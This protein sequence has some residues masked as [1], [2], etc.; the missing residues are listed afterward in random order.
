MRSLRLLVSRQWKILSSSRLNYLFLAAQAVVIGLLIA[1]VD[2]NLVLQMFLSL[3][4]TL[5]FGCSN[6]AQQIVSELAIYRRERLAGLGI[7]TYVISK[8]LFLLAITGVQAV[9][10]YAMILIFSPIFHRETAPDLED[11]VKD[12]TGTVPDK[13]TREFRMEF[14]DNGNWNTLAGG[15]DNTSSATAA[16]DTAEP[17]NSAL[18]FEVV[19]APGSAEPTPASAPAAAPSAYFNPTGLHVTDF[20]YRVLEKLAAFFRV[21]ENV[22]DRL[23]L[24]RQSDSSFA[25]LASGT[26]SW[27]GFIF[28]LIALRFGALFGAAL[29]GVALG[30]AVSALVNTPTQSVMWVPLILIPQILFGSFV[31]I[32]PEMNGA[33]LRFSEALPSFNLERI[34]DVALIYGRAAPRMTNQSKIPAFIDSPDKQ[35][36]VEWDG[37][38]TRY[39][40]VSEVNKSWQN[41]IVL[42]DL[43]GA[44]E[45]RLGVSGEPKDTVEERA[46][47]QLAKGNPYLNLA[48]AGTSA[49]VLAGW[50]IGCYSVAVFALY[51]RQT[52]K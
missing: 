2:D 25:A 30:L 41:L 9:M 29:V 43:L 27:K 5:W 18:D 19:T 13:A 24:R 46:D 3:I 8:F 22:L 44:R 32:I 7:H 40:R 35:E 14:F 21:R 49:F 51:R 1:W 15:E 12:Y 52:G 4:A 45:K 50:A 31:V 17:A 6:G 39:D 23:K 47:V 34:M 42:R 37:K 26:V 16:G 10:L 20:Q 48:P 36:V 38:Q 28:D 11:A 33:V